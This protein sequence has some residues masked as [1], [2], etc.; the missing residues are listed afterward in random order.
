[1]LR[2]DARTIIACYAYDKAR[3]LVGLRL[4]LATTA[5]MSRIIIYYMVLKLGISTHLFE[6]KWCRYQGLDREKMLV[7]A[8]TN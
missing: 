8:S 3:R 7:L 2:H 6:K 1:M 5:G 4:R